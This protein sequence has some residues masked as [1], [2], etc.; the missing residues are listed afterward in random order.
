MLFFLRDLQLA[1]PHQLPFTHVHLGGGWQ[2]WINVLPKD[3]SSGQEFEPT[4]LGL[5][6]K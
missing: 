3:A 2:M 5:R 4:I 1:L 6:V